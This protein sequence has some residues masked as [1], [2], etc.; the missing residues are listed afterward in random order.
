M[1]RLK[2]DITPTVSHGPLW[3]HHLNCFWLNALTE[4]HSDVSYKQFLWVQAPNQLRHLTLRPN[5]SPFITS[6]SRARLFGA[7]PLDPPRPPAERARCCRPRRSRTARGLCGCRWCSAARWSRPLTPSCCGQLTRWAGR[8]WRGWSAL[9]CWPQPTRETG[10]CW[11]TMRGNC[12]RGSLGDDHIRT[13][14]QHKVILHVSQTKTNS[15]ISSRFPKPKPRN[16]FCKKKWEINTMLTL[17]YCMDST[18]YPRPQ[19]ESI[20]AWRPLPPHLPSCFWRS[21]MYW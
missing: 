21:T 9:R 14:Q 19:S 8:P 10:C 6:E 7:H 20:T 4:S 5:Y 13:T 18:N 3:S 17:K 1:T 12:W 15:L 11:W 16:Q 2:S